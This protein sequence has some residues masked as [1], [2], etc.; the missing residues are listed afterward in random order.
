[1]RLLLRILKVMF[2]II[3]LVVIYVPL[4]AEAKGVSIWGLSWAYYAVIGVTILVISIGA[5]IKG[6]YSE[7]KGFHSKAYR[8]DIENKELENQKLK[9]ELGIIKPFEYEDKVAGQSSWSQ[10]SIKYDDKVAGHKI[11]FQVSPRYFKLFVDNRVYYFNAETGEFDG[12]SIW[13]PP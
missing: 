8:L 7:N 4:I 6:L 2:V 13:S 11:T 5:M 9:N 12:T 3:G 10:D 1:M